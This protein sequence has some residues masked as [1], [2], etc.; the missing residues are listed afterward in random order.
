VNTSNLTIYVTVTQQQTVLFEGQIS[1][2]INTGALSSGNGNSLISKLS[3]AAASFATGNPNSG[4]NSLTAFI[5]QV[6]TFATSVPPLLTATQ[7]QSLVSAANAII[8]LANPLQL[9]SSVGNTITAGTSFNLTVTA[10]DVYGNVL[11][12]YTGAVKFADSVT[13]ATLPGTYTFTTGL[14]KDNGV[15][16]FKNLVLKTK[17]SQILTVI[18]TKTGKLLGSLTVTVI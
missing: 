4:V 3:S 8:T 6:N 18:D 16:T 11:P 7:A 12:T 13:G 14:G 15:H 1:T 2:L 9:V 5:N 10:I 17:G